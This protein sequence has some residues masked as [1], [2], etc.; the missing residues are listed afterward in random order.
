[1][2]YSIYTL[3]RQ[4]GEYR[5]ALLRQYPSQEELHRIFEYNPNDG[6]FRWKVKKAR[7]VQIGNAAGTLHPNGY[8]YIKIAD[9]RYFAH[10]L[11]WIY[12]YGERPDMLDHIDRCRS[13]NRIENLRVCT[14]SQNKYNSS[15]YCNN[16]SGKRGVSWHK[17]YQKW[18]AYINI[19]GR[20]KY[21]GRF[22]SIEEATI[23][24]ETAAR[25]LQ[26]EFIYH[27]NATTS[28]LLDIR[29]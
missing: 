8:V 5:K 29:P 27:D 20:R 1:M 22:P 14:G 15:R 23:A 21:L 12:I 13:N 19:D 17:Q 11:A 4:P 18:Q 24:Y 2:E 6:L 10:V 7:R 16:T 3:I 28:G 26:G 25:E 9:I